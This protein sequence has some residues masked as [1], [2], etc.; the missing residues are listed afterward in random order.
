ME[1]QRID[2][3]TVQCHM[4]EEEMQEYGFAI[5]DFFTDQEKSRNFLEQLVERAEEEI[6][7]EAEGGMISMQLMRLP[8]NSLNIIFTDRAQD[9]L[10]TML[11]QIQSLAGM[12]DENTAENIVDELTRQIKDAELANTT[13]AKEDK[14]KEKAEKKQRQAFTEHLK[15]VEKIKKEKEKR[16]A[17]AAKVYAFACMEHI[18]NFVLTADYKKNIP[19]KLYKDEKTGKWYLLIKKGKM[20]MEEYQALC[21]HISEYG[22]LCSQ[23]PFVEQYCRE[24]YACLI[25]KHAVRTI[26]EYLD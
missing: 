4:T 19:S 23:Q 16:I 13:D 26:K 17:N 22:S 12:I 11:N 24:H 2:K 1:F 3:N 15:E 21:R 8:D 9:G 10:H 6:G 20:T 25:P 7:Y 14:E 5:E 18:E